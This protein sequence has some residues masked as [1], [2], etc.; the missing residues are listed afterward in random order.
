MEKVL[1]YGSGGH[2]KVVIACLVSEQ[3]E[4]VGLFDD[5]PKQ[6][7][8][9]GFPLLGAYSPL[10]HREAKL[11]VTIGNNAVRK[12]ISEQ[13]S[14][15]IATAVHAQSLLAKD[16]ELGEGTVILPGAI[17]QSDAQIGKHVI[18]NT[19]A[20]VEHD[21]IVGDFAHIAPGATLCGLV[22]IGEGTLVGAN[23]VIAPTVKVGKWCQISAGSSVT[24]DVPD[25]S[26]V[27]GVPGRVVKNIDRA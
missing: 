3:K 10:V 9:K 21:C 24:E 14:H 25:Y 6:A 1:L 19:G 11:M 13:V 7:E 17:V 2:A 20:I 22:H 16:A 12:K 5:H 15:P 26:L 27:M 23:A 4:V 8:F 18:V